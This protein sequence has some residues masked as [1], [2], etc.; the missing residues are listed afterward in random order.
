[1]HVEFHWAADE[2]N[3]ARAY[4]T[5]LIGLA[6]D[7]IVA[8]GPLTAAVQQQTRTLPIVF[9]PVPDPVGLG[10]IASLAQ[11]GGNTT[12]FVS[13]EERISA[14]WLELLKELAPNAKRVGDPN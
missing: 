10:F 9:V 7:I 3:R 12:G 4:A 11:P 1:M 13:F 14:Q 6:P 5:E 8:H 2:P